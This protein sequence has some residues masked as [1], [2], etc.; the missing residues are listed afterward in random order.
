ML[1]VGARDF[2]AQPRRGENL[3]GIAEMPRVDGVP[4]SFHHV[5]RVVTEHLRHELTLVHTD[6]VLTGDR[7]SCL[8]AVGQYF[9]GRLR[10]ALGLSGYVAVVTNQ[11]MQ[12]AVTG[13][14][15]IGD[16]KAAASLELTN[17][18]EH[19]GKLRTWDHPILHVIV[20]RHPSHRGKRSFAASPDPCTLRVVCR[21][22]DARGSRT[23]AD[24]FDERKQF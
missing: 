12:I 10:R 22:F 17:P 8:D 16:S 4:D 1:A 11:R 23:P 2:A 20:R 13:V 15:D 14:E 7:P 21:D 3:A 9:S 18:G 19:L 5:E 6:A 24:L